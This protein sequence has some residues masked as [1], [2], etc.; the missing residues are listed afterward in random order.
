MVPSDQPTGKW[1]VSARPELGLDI[2]VD[3]SA[4]AKASGD[5]KKKQTVLILSLIHI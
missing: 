3:N 2:W 1:G 5:S 4:A